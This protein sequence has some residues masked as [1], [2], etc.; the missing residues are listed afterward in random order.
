MNTY[1]AA[2]G[3]CEKRQQPVRALRLPAC[4]EYRINV[5][6][7]VMHGEL[8]NECFEQMPLE[9]NIDQEQLQF[10]A[11]TNSVLAWRVGINPGI[12][13]LT[14]INEGEPPAK[15]P[16]CEDNRINVTAVDVHGDLTKECFEQMPLEFKGDQKQLQFCE[17]TNSEQFPPF[18][19]NMKPFPGSENNRINA[20]AVV[21]HGGLTEECF[22]L[23]PLEFYGDRKQLQFCEETNSELR[24]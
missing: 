9:F 14:S 16:E 7:V 19:P 3:A 2:I 17:E 24:V 21:V 1:S 6:A 5:T 13:L 20:T 4:E 15:R 8:T 18:K 10:C 11:E 22:E 12:K 23:M